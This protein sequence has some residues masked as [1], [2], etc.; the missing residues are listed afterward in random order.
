M[1]SSI[2]SGVALVGA[3]AIALAPVQPVASPLSNVHLP[4]VFSAA[5]VELTAAFNPVAPWVDLIT[6]TVNN[7]STLG[8]DWLADPAPALRQLGANWFGYGQT[9]VT[10]LGGVVSAT[11]DYLTTTVPESLTTA[12][13]QIAQG[14]LSGAAATIN[15]ALGTAIL[16]LGLPL[17]P[18]VDIPGKI[19]DNL[20]A[21]VKTVTGLQTV[22]PA[23]IGVLGPIEGTIQSVGDSAQKVLDSAAAGDAVA[24]LNAAV[25]TLPT[26]ISAAINGYVATDG[27]TYPGLLSPP[28]EFGNNAGIAYTLMV[29]IPKAIAT[30]LGATQPTLAGRQP[31]AVAASVVADEVTTSTQTATDATEQASGTAGSGSDAASAEDNAGTE[32]AS[33]STSVVR[34]A[35]KAQPRR[36]GGSG[37]NAESRDS[38]ASD[39]GVA[40]K[41]TGGDTGKTRSAR[42]AASS[43]R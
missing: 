40:K 21:V 27:T 2:A 29:S 28:D 8:E 3:G 33:G 7:V 10:A 15:N 11:Y 6:A 4:A 22:L 39:T 14:N 24:A 18:V 41:T 32:A 25:N 19:A 13:Q 1:R 16:T 17:F 31:A 5:G 9:T 20:A 37:V 26:V 12:F 30:A 42:H 34:G 23:L 36:V 43:G 38:A 35:N